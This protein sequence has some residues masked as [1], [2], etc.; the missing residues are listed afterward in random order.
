MAP[1]FSVKLSCTM[2]TVCAMPILPE[3]SMY[4]DVMVRCFW[5]T[6]EFFASA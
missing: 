4:A 1:K 5:K 3:T 6:S 2:S